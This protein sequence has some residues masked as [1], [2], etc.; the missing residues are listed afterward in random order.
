MQKH[1]F[2]SFNQEGIHLVSGKAKSKIAF[3]EEKYFMI[4]MMDCALN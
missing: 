2:I 1:I 4:K 3:L